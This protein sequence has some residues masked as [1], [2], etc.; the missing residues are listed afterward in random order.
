[1]SLNF[2]GDM[3][4]WPDGIADFGGQGSP[5][6][7]KLLYRGVRAEIWVHQEPVVLGQGTSK[8]I[9]KNPKFPEHLNPR[10]TRLDP[11]QYLLRRIIRER[12]SLQHQ[13]I[14]EMLGIDTSFGLYP[15]L[16]FEFCENLSLEAYKT[17]HFHDQYD[18]IKY[19][20]QILEG[21][22]YLHTFPTPIAHGDLNPSNI[23]VNTHGVLKLTLFSLSQLAANIP[24]AQGTLA[25]R[26]EIVRYLSPEMLSDVAIPSVKSDMWAYGCVVFWL[27]ANLEPYHETKREQD[28]E[29]LIQKGA[30]PND[31]QLLREE[32]EIGGQFRQN[33]RREW[34]FN[35]ISDRAEKCWSSS[36]WPS[37]SEFLQFLREFLGKTDEDTD[38]WMSGVSN[39]SG[40][41]IRPPILWMHG[42]NTS[43]L[44]RYS[45]SHRQPGQR[46]A[47]V[48]INWTKASFKR[49][50]FRFQTE[51]IIKFSM[52][53]QSRYGSS[54][55]IASQSSIK[56]EIAILTQLKHSNI[57][58]LWGYEEDTFGS[59]S[60][61]AI[62]TEFCP[63][64]TLRE[65]LTRRSD[66]LDTSARLLLVRNVLDSVNYLHEHV[67]QGTI[68]H[69]NLN[70]DKSVVVDKYGTAKLRNFEFSFQ[71]KHNESLYGVATLV[72]APTLAPAPS[73]WHPPE[74]FTQESDSDWPLLTRYTDLWATGCLLVAI[75]SNLEPYPG[76]DLPVVFPRIHNNEKPYSK[77]VCTHKGVWN[78]AEQLWG[79]STIDR[80]SAS[81]A[82]QELSQC[83]E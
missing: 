40:T 82:L 15:G 72:R 78:V 28:V 1:M 66:N 67:A 5:S 33:S 13:N 2:D 42:G 37:A 68:V 10:K 39:L 20:T 58:F 71:Y 18:L 79:D 69:G 65:Y 51:A 34:L 57:C 52:S 44:W 6:N 26:P 8:Y 60:L 63:N 45:T 9:I 70:M 47:S 54:D 48:T 74:M 80:I 35:G 38:T 3:P 50:L 24:Q 59:P 46:M 83:I 7:R 19:A 62:V 32:A 14:V 64:G 53:G 49:G 73:R 11:F 17:K 61:P 27:F 29:K 21:L 25:G 56:H 81:K 30:L 12:Y 31:A 16:V 43:G 76:I 36:G 4:S 55:H 22:G 75:F 77:D 23:V 41:I